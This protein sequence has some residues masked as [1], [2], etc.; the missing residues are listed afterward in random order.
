ML[1]NYKVA[2]GEVVGF[3]YEKAKILAILN[4]PNCTHLRIYY[5]YDTVAADVKDAQI[6]VGVDSA[7]KDLSTNVPALM[8]EYGQ[9]SIDE[10][11]PIVPALS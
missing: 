8:A 10:T 3:L 6:I 1:K 7:N 9:H 4:Q 2:H 11:S 5:G